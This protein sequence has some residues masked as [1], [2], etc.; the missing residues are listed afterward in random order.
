MNGRV[1][2]L[3][4]FAQNGPNFSAKAS[5]IRKALKKF[6]IE[7]VFL[8]A[9]L[10]LKGA[11]LPFDSASLGADSADSAE[12]PDFKGWWYTVDD[13]DIE[14]A[15]EAVRECCK[16]KGP[17]TGVLG[18]SQGA[19]LAAILAN[20][21]SEI[22]PGHP[23]LKF[24]IFYSGF[25]VNNQKY[26]KYYEPKISIPTLHIFGELDTVV[27][28]ERSQRLIDECCVPETTLT[29][30]HPGGHYVPNI[31]DLINKEVSWVLNALDLDPEEI[32]ANKNNKGK[33]QSVTGEK[34]K[35]QLKRE[36]KAKQ[37]ESGTSTPSKETEEDKTARELGELND[38]FDKIGKI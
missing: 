26:W 19:G 34:S 5:G 8:N 2:C 1:L 13:F 27:S 4:G 23:G 11:D 21:F 3:H 12:A 17:F 7:T 20:K 9:P 31:K 22:V 30:K 24:G 33:A 25:K 28:E 35:R 29:L 18:F 15:F 16:E 32:K 38:E 14:P 37:K 6:D 36:Q 10:Q